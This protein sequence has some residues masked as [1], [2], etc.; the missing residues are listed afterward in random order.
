METAIRTFL[1]LSFLFPNSYLSYLNS[2]RISTNKTYNGGLFITDVFAMP[3]GCS[4]WPAWWSVGPNW[5]EGG[6]ID[7]IEG[8]NTNSQNQYTL[9]TA[10]GCQLDSTIST[11]LHTAQIVD[12]QCASSAA[13]NDGCAFI[14]TDA[15]SFGQN[16]NDIGGGVY[17]HLWDN[18]GIKAWHF[19]RNAV[20]PDID[21]QQP[22][23][24]N[25]G[26]PAAFWSAKSCDVSSHFF[27][28]VLTFDTT[29]CGDWA[30]SVYSSSGCPG[31][32]AEA[33]SNPS[34]FD[35]ARWKINYVAVYN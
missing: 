15:R 23:P 33:V 20:P 21:A 35:N 11:S 3:T 4:V 16:F 13:N 34:N 30:G 24:A 29:L 5:P 22:N 9:H 14:D 2:V 27:D 10:D 18:T 25:W 12:S 7:I 32:C 26:S 6:E 1:S 17:A 31:T 8:V 28:H 19:P